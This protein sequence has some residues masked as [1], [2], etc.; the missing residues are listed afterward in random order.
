[1]IWKQYNN[2]QTQKQ[3]HPHKANR[4]RAL[5]SHITVSLKK[6]HQGNPKYAIVF[7]IISKIK[8]SSHALDYTMI[9]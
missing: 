7:K 2:N 5:L 9:K 3:K 8:I 6:V 1:M 4:I